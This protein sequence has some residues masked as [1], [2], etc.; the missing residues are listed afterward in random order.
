MR[1]VVIIFMVSVLQ[2]CGVSPKDYSDAS[3]LEPVDTKLAVKPLWI[4]GT[5]DVPENEH[6]QLPP[7]VVDGNIYV[8][9]IAGKISMINAEN[10]EKLWSQSLDE[11]ISGGPGAGAGMIYVGTR[12]AEIISLDQKTG[13]EIW[14]S[15]VSSEML[16]TP[17]YGDGS[18]YVQ[19]ID[20]KISSIDATT[21]KL[22][23]VYSHNTPKLTLHGTASPIAVRNQ[24]I[25]GFADGKLVSINMST[26]ELNWSTS[27]STPKGRTD[28]ERLSDI[29]GVIKTAG[30]S[31]YVISYQGH[32]A[33]VS[34]MDG[35]IQW[36][37][38]MSSYT[39][40]AIDKSHIFIS[41]ADGNV[42]ALDARSGATL[43]KQAG[44]MGREISSPEVISNA[45]V[46]GDFDGYVHWLSEEDGQFIARQSLTEL[47]EGLYPTVYETLDDEL[48]SQEY[49]RLVTVKPLAVGNTLFVRDNFGALAAFRIE[50]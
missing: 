17:I 49:H 12:N 7:L 22:N 39:G 3:K 2:A 21:G 31:V 42:W 29:D 23:W 20:G 47:W 8:A 27:I 37:R 10:G 43:W 45:V 11:V 30:D 34:I 38:K 18:L 48:A 41:D 25:T 50:E 44:L 1:L 19:T 28:L 5:G 26:G 24:I 13:R 32:V 36:S 40:L 46:V 35:D 14:R 9:N 15:R 16:S 6:A 4:K 33:S